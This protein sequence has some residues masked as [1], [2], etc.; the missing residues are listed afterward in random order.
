MNKKTMLEKSIK[1][2]IK[3][4]KKINIISSINNESNKEY[5]INKRKYKIIKEIDYKY[6]QNEKKNNKIII[7]LLLKEFIAISNN[8]K[9]LNY[10][11]NIYLIF[12]ILINISIFSSKKISRNLILKNNEITITI[13]QKGEHQII[14]DFYDK[15]PSLVKINGEEVNLESNKKYK[16]ISNS[17]TIIMEWNYTITDCSKMFEE[18][19][20]IISIDLSKFDASNVT[21]MYGMFYNC[22]DLKYINFRSPTDLSFFDTSSVINMEGLFYNCSGLTSLDLS[23]F[24]TSSVNNMGEL[25]YNCSGLT[26]L[27]L[28]SFNTSSVTDMNRLFYNCTGLASL[29]LSSLDTSSVT[30]MNELFYNCINLEYVNLKTLNSNN[31]LTDIDKMFGGCKKLQYINLYSLNTNKINNYIN[32]FEESSNNFTYCIEN[33]E[34]NNFSNYINSLDNTKRDCSNNCYPENRSLIV[35]T[36]ICKYF[37][38]SK[39]ETHKFEYNHNCYINCPKKTK[40]KNNNLCEDLNCINYYDYNQTECINEIP[41]GYYLNDSSEKTIDKCHPDCKTCEEKNTINNTNCKSCYSGKYLHNGNCISN[42]P[43]G[44]N[45]SENN[46]CVNDD[47]NV[48]KENDPINDNEG[49][50]FLDNQKK[51]EN[52]KSVEII[53]AECEEKLKD[54]YNIPKDQDLITKAINS[55]NEGIPNIGYEVYYSS[56]GIESEKLNLSVCKGLK[57]GIS[58]PVSINEEDIDKY[59]PSS[60]YYNDIC[61]PYTSENGT[62]ISLDDRKKEFVEKNMTLCE[63]DCDFI[64]YDSKTKNVLCSCDVKIE[65]PLMSEIS[66]NKEKLYDKFI[67][68]KNTIN[69]EIMKCYYIL[70]SKEGISNNISI[71]IILPIKIF[72]L[73]SIIIFYLKDYKKLNFIIN[74]IL[75]YKNEKKKINKNIEGKEI[76]KSEAIIKNFKSLNKRNQRNQRNRRIKQKKNNVPTSKSTLKINSQINKK[77][78]EK[79]SNNNFPPIKNSRNKKYTINYSINILKTNTFSSKKSKKNIHISNNLLNSNSKLNKEVH[80]NLDENVMKFNDYELNILSY[81]KAIKFD[82]RNYYHYFFS[83]LKTKHILIFAF[84]TSDYNSRIIKIDLLFISF[85]IF[86]TV[87]ALFFNDSTMHKIYEDGGSFNFIYQLPQIIYSTLISSVFNIIIKKLSL[88]QNSILEIKEEKKNFIKKKEKIW[89]CL[90]YKF[91]F[92]FII[93]FIFL[94]LFLYYLSCFGAVFKN[95]QIHLIKDTIISFV[96]SLIY[97]LVLYLLPGIFRIPALRNAEKK[98]KII[99]NFSKLI[100][101]IL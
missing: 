89:K 14:S 50:N 31:N 83:L 65:L 49:M 12:F 85:V 5:N 100:E 38:C 80:Q 61:Y 97:P 44:F 42:C 82:K 34:N 53:L 94:L 10:I 39:N 81:E 1:I 88:S 95:T 66:F 13:N 23:S 20:N 72:H 79:K 25:F 6:R 52:N 54:Y 99:Y 21:N 84:Y 96:L 33:I 76:I 32:M 22:N 24:N 4:N 68:I 101:S 51:N 40:V 64:D 45:T 11:F 87:N 58:I 28:S 77:K 16:F 78:K 27:D 98:R 63:E 93:S 91:I 56:N 7:N 3:E 73:I 35:E 60:N 43:N 18:L 41:D 36:N 71:Y 92:F 17:N 48:S 70:F 57:I 47:Y 2:L 67:D 30:N 15:I 26:S 9:Y 46:T 74:D 69:I 86:L 37:I 19:K 90:Y 75:S 59:N 8:I 29:D 62:D 55:G